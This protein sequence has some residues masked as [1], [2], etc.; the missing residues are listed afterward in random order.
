MKIIPFIVENKDKLDWRLLASNSNAI[1]ML[2]ENMDKLDEDALH[3]ST[4]S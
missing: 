2:E 1:E 4:K 3:F